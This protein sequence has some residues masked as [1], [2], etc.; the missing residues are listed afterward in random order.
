MASFSILSQ[1]ARSSVLATKSLASSMRALS[2][3]RSVLPSSTS[4]SQKQV[5]CLSQSALHP[6]GCQRPCCRPT[7]SAKSSQTTGVA[8]PRSGAVF[9]NQQ[10]RGMKV[11]SSI[12]K[13]CEHCKVV[14]RKAGKRHVGYR[15]IICSANPRHKQRQG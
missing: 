6:S 7:L 5:R 13:R 1:T 14:R 12:K 9:Q 3:A 2:L 8:A 10:T 11:H 4:S 15:Y